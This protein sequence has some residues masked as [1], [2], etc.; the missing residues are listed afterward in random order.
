MEQD[1]LNWEE[2]DQADVQTYNNLPLL[3]QKDLDNTINKALEHAAPEIRHGIKNNANDFYNSMTSFNYTEKEVGYSPDTWKNYAPKHQTIKNN[4][5]QLEHKQDNDSYN[6]AVNSIQD[7]KNYFTE[8]KE[9]VIQQDKNFNNDL[10]SIKDVMLEMQKLQ[11]IQAQKDLLFMQQIDQ[12]RQEAKNARP[13]IS[14]ELMK[15][16]RDQAAK[17]YN[18]IKN[19]PQKLQTAIKNKSDYLKDNTIKKAANVFDKA[20]KYLEEKRNKI[21]EKSPLYQKE[22]SQEMAQTKTTENVQTQTITNVSKSPEVDKTKTVDNDKSKT[23]SQTSKLQ[24]AAK[25]NTQK[26]TRNI[27]IQTTQTHSKE[28]SMSR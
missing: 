20:I 28:K 17:T 25:T 14:A 3:I 11:T 23:L 26:T 4:L 27:Q 1:F 21:L 10:N 6:K 12:L 13:I 5:I 15:S 22:N 16:A 9:Q 19:S 8:Q 7:S 18:N 2:I 24:D